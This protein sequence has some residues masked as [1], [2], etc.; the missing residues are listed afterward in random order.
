MVNEEA[1]PG[2]TVRGKIDLMF[3]SYAASVS[4]NKQKGIGLQYQGVRRH[5]WKKSLKYSQLC[6]SAAALLPLPWVI[7]VNTQT[8]QTLTDQ[9]KVKSMMHAY[10][11]TW[12][13]HTYTGTHTH[14]VLKNTLR[15]AA[16]MK[17]AIHVANLGALKRL[18]QMFSQ[19]LWAML[20][21]GTEWK[22]SLWSLTTQPPHTPAKLL[23]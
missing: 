8:A 9:N 22:K 19:K 4:I 18:H 14:A 2:L 21:S 10:L 1:F 12:K 11:H 17:A 20:L 7:Y 5:H 23:S 15:Q 16:S 6:I 3:V 13:T